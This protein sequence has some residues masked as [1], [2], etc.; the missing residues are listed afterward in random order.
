MAAARTAV[1]ETWCGLAAEVFGQRV[2]QQLALADRL[3]AQLSQVGRVLIA[4]A[5]ELEAAQ[6]LERRAAALDEACLPAEKLAADRLWQEAREATDEAHRHLATGL[7]AVQAEGD[8]GGDG[9]WHVGPPS[10]PDWADLVNSLVLAPKAFAER[11]ALRTQTAGEL[12]GLLKAA[13]RDGSVVERAAARVDYRAA[14]REVRELRRVESTYV[15]LAEKV[16]APEWLGRLDDP[17]VQG[18]PVLS[19]VPV[20]AIALVGVSSYLDTRH[21][22]SVGMA[23][24]KNVAAT[25]SGMLAYSGAAAGL[26][27]AGLVGAPV[28]LGAVGA[29]FVVSWGVGEVVEHYGDDISEAAGEVAGAV[30]DAA[31]A[32][33]DAAGDAV[34]A[35][36]GAASDAWHGVFG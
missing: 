16:P 18:V 7:H 20:S 2:D 17:L 1:L 3:C 27:A 28:I 21:G 35:V 11:A 15:Q 5:R 34:D 36:G 31:D 33:G 22:M 30:G 25:G 8:A 12:V 13:A 9:G 4:F 24:T 29:G 32:V 23:V 10:A 26:A 6:V 14:L 19:K